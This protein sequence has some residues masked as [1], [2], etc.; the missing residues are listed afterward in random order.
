MPIGVIFN[1]SVVVF[2]GLIGAFMG[3]KLPKKVLDEL[4]AIFGLS[5]ISMGITLI[6]QLQNLTPVILAIILGAIFGEIF[7]LEHSLTNIIG[8][9]VKKSEGDKTDKLI[10]VIVLFCFS[11]TGIFGALNEGF[12]GDSSIMITKSIL[13]FFTAITFGATVGYLVALVAVPQ[14]IFSIIL[15]FSAGFIIPILND[16]MIA[17]FKACGGIVTLA[18][19]IKLARIKSFN[20]INILPAIVF[21]IPISYL[22]Q[23]II[24]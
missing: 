17:D 10:T 13:D 22:W 16:G 3:S 9:V 6:V 19:G 8:R 21:V 24:G 2:G 18:V 1:S 14:F 23:S 4:P 12:T 20:V 7:Q 15:F 11:G 5:A